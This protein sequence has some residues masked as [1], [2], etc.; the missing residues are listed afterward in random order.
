MP[1]G[2]RVNIT[3]VETGFLYL[4]ITIMEQQFPLNVKHPIHPQLNCAILLSDVISNG[5]VE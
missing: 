2:K 4:I 5:K 1:R 3:A